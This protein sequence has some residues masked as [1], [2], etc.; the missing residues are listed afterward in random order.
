M[1]SKLSPQPKGGGSGGHSHI[2]A[3]RPRSPKPKSKRQNNRG[4]LQLQ[5]S[6]SPQLPSRPESTTPSS[7]PDTAPVALGETPS[8]LLHPHQLPLLSV[9]PPPVVVQGDSGSGAFASSPEESPGPPN[10]TPNPSPGDQTHQH[11]QHIDPFMSGYSQ[12]IGQ[13]TGAGAEQGDYGRQSPLSTSSGSGPFV[14]EDVTNEEVKQLMHA[15]S[16]GDSELEFLL[17]SGLRGVNGSPKGFL[18]KVLMLFKILK[19]SLLTKPSPPPPLLNPSHKT[20]PIRKPETRH[21][22][23]NPISLLISATS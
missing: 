16:N 8:P 2:P 6:P 18:L 17:V 19:T 15:D 9:P 7:A 4:G 13:N 23:L 20:P 11:Q 10:P 1:S 5:P 21:Q 22:F 12:P 14:E 3:L